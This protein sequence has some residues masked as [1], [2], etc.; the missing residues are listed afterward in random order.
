MLPTDSGRSGRCEWASGRAL[1]PVGKRGEPLARKAAVR[2]PDTLE[3]TANH[4]A[5][6]HFEAEWPGF[7]VPWPQGTRADPAEVD[8]TWVANRPVPYTNCNARRAAGHDD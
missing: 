2:A 7:R 8:V 5:R 4:T 1:R 3:V 6:R